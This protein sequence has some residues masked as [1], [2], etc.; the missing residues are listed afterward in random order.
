MN[1]VEKI[2]PG[3]PWY[4]IVRELIKKYEKFKNLTWHGVFQGKCVF[5]ILIHLFDSISVHIQFTITFIELV[6]HYPISICDWSILCFV[7][8]K[9]V[10]PMPICCLDVP[11][12]LLFALPHPTWP[13]GS[14]GNFEG[15]PN[16]KHRT[17]RITDTPFG[18]DSD[19][20]RI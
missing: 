15:T 18:I 9:I 1:T 14:R 17:C 11:D 12:Q 20:K 2:F 5:R 3:I 13:L 16:D 4:S 10:V 6:N 19:L 7:M 8:V